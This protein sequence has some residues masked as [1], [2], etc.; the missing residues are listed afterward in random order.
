MNDFERMLNENI[1]KATKIEVMYTHG[2]KVVAEF[3]ENEKEELKEYLKTHYCHKFS[4]GSDG[5]MLVT[6]ARE[7]YKPCKYCGE[8][9]KTECEDLL[10]PECRETFGHTFYSEL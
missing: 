8:P 10:C 7:G 9:H 1:D 6:I 4:I 5:Y 3:K 2:R